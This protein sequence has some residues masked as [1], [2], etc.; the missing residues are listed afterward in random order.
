MLRSRRLKDNPT[1]FGYGIE[2][3]NPGRVIYNEGVYV[4]YRYYESFNVPVAFPFGYG[5]S[6]TTFEYSGFE[7]SPI[8]IAG[9]FQVVIN[10]K[11]TGKLAGKEV[12]QGY[13]GDVVSS[14]VKP[15][16]E[17]KGFTVISLSPGQS[18]TVIIKLARDGLRFWD[19]RRDWWT[20]EKA[21]LEVLVGSTIRDPNHK[22]T[23]SLE[24][25]A[26]RDRDERH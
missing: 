18:R 25:L 24:R 6:Y 1:S 3:A 15:I 2:T 22:A 8:N 26:W 14:S 21:E 5:L 11:N 7:V 19:E 10:V 23:V 20:A 12:V 16:L 13:I 17:L 4:G 9:Q